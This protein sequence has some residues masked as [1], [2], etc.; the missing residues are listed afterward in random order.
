MYINLTIHLSCREKETKMVDNLE[1]V[2]NRIAKLESLVG[3]FDKL[4]QI[5]V[6]FKFSLN[7]NSDKIKP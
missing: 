7:N 5:K 4:E 2:E 6:N 3:R 1:L